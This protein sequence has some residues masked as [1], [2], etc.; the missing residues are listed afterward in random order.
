MFCYYNGFERRLPYPVLTKEYLTSMQNLKHLSIGIHL[1][2]DIDVE[3]DGLVDFAFYQ[4]IPE[5]ISKFKNLNKLRIECLAVK[6][7]L[8]ER[9]LE[10]LINLED[11]ELYIVFDAIDSDVKYL[12]KNLNKLKKL[13]LG[14]NKMDIL[15]SSFVDYLVDLEEVNLKLNENKLIERGSFKNS[16]KLRHL[17][18]KEKY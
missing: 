9:F 17:N 18:L 5:N 16:T 15:R 14:R 4:K 2:I 12:F 10:D 8:N 13:T 7:S 1:Q 3:L 6:I 11:L